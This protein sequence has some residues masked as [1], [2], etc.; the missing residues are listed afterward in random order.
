MDLRRQTLRVPRRG[1]VG[2][3]LLELL[4]VMVVVGVLA[5]IAVP[6]LVMQRRKAYETSAKSDVKA[7]T[8]EVFAQFVDTPGVLTVSGSAGTWELQR[9]G[10]VVATGRLSEHNIVSPASFVSA[11]GDFCLSVRNTKVDAQFWTADDI[12]LRSGDCPP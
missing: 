3:T 7:I 12:G 8:S 11:D 2:F 6:A 5:A 4:V 9:N 10:V 1:D